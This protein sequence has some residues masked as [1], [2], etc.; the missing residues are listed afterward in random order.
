[1]SSVEFFY[2]IFQS[3]LLIGREHLYNRPLPHMLTSKLPPAVPSHLQHF[4]LGF[5]I[6]V[7]VVE[8]LSLA[9]QLSASSP[10]KILYSQSLKKLS[11]YWQALLLLWGLAIVIFFLLLSEVTKGEMNFLPEVFLN[12]AYLFT[13]I[14]WG[15]FMRVCG[16]R[17][18]ANINFKNHNFI[19][20]T[21]ADCSS[22]LAR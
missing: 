22:Q 16:L 4:I 20:L 18:S 11:S 21:M 10:S 12:F 8:R 17:K 15:R 2:L 9:F 5:L 1:M 14:K 19:L 6:D 3:I 13:N 7:L